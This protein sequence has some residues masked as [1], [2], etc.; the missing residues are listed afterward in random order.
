LRAKGILNLADADR[1]Y[2][3]QAVHMMSEAAFTGP[4]PDKDRRQSR[5]VFIG[6]DLD[7]TALKDGFAACRA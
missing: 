3:F 2:V 7:T 1:R 5:L 6:R 4:W